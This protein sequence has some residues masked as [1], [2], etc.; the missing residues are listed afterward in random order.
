M[1]KLGD[2]I[3]LEGFEAIEHG[4]MAVIRKIVGSYARQMSDSGKEFKKLLLV[5]KQGNGFELKATAV[6]G[7][8]EKSK[9]AQDKNLFYG[10]DRVLSGL[11][12][13]V[14]Q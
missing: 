8:S 14:K 12:D 9:E 1:I 10:L 4:K 13:L 2:S 3:E 5:L 7:G 6:V 11:L